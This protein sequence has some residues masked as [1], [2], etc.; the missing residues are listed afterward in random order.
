M[1]RREENL[2]SNAV[3]SAGKHVSKTTGLLVQMRKRDNY[4]RQ[5]RWTQFHKKKISNSIQNMA[6]R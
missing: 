3:K 1:S 5:N 6:K 4:V 2:S